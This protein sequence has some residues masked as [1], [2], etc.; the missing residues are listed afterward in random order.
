MRAKKWVTIV[1][2]SCSLLAVAL[3][4]IFKC[5]KC[6]MGYDISL[7]IL[8]SALLGFIMSLI[9]YFA[10]RRNAMEQFWLSA[11]S[12]LIKFRKIKYIDFNEPEELV[13]A[14]IAENYENKLFQECGLPITQ[15]VGMTES[16]ENRN[17]FIEW[18]SEH[19]AVQ[20]SEHADTNAILDKIYMKRMEVYEDL[21]KSVIESYIELSQV[22]LSEL[23]NAYGNLSFIF[24][25]KTIRFKAYNEIYNQIRTIRNKVLIETFHFNLWKEDKGNFVVCMNKV[26]EFNKMFFSEKETKQ[27]GF[28]SVSIYQKQFDDIEENLE[29]FR[30]KIYFRGKKEAIKRIPVSGKVIKWCNLQDKK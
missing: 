4:P 5:C 12:V 28:K 20:S 18:M 24:A 3:L 30:S 19:N 25:N 1:T 8:G 14:C 21:V 22:N 9:E 23:D 10:E 27:D 29:E 11:R 7:A 26:I 16:Y 13:I 2:F 17:R 15:L 6:D